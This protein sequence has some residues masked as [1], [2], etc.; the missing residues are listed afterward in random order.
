MLFRSANKTITLKA[1]Q[2]GMDNKNI[3]WSLNKKGKKFCYLN[4]KSGKTV[5][6][7]AKKNKTGKAIITVK[8]GKLS[9]K[10]TVRIVL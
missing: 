3:K 10:V 1:I 8:C 7:K 4:K 9:K 2:T 5:K 6:L